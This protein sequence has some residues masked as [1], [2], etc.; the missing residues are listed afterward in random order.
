MG[1][2]RPTLYWGSWP[3]SPGPLQRYL[4]PRGT[5]QPSR[6]P[7]LP[8]LRRLISLPAGA[9]QTRG[10]RPS[11]PVLLRM[12]GGSC[13]GSA[14][15]GDTIKH[16]ILAKKALGNNLLPSLTLVNRGPLLLM[17]NL[18][19]PIVHSNN[20]NPAG[21]I[22][23]PIAPMRSARQPGNSRYITYQGFISGK[24]PISHVLAMQHEGL[25]WAHSQLKSLMNLAGIPLQRT[26]N[27]LAGP[28]GHLRRGINL[29]TS[30]FAPTMGV[31][32]RNQRGGWSSSR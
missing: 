29:R 28:S 30:P 18:S 2:P 17:A 19:Y 20:F 16:N 7:A 12:A 11:S 9:G 14:N 1:G 8:A 27:L 5:H 22:R 21:C 3:A 25:S 31:Q 23:Y 6:P 15:K 32:Q 13:A 24:D 4:Q 10:R 26:D